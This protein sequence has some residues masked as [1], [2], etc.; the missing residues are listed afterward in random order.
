[1]DISSIIITLLILLFSVVLHELSHG[2]A[3]D[4]LGD[5]T[6]RHAGRL[7]LNPLPHLDPIGSI[8]LPLFLFM[9]NSPVIF[10]AAKPVPVNFANLRDPKRDMALVSLAG[11][12][13]N[14]ILAFAFALPI[15][16][17]MISEG[18]PGFSILLQAVLMNLVLGIFNL[19]PIPP[20]DGSKILASIV[21]DEMMYKILSLERYGFLLIILFLYTG[22][23][24]AVLVPILNALSRVFLGFGIV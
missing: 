21:S 19:I 20:L 4:K 9:V 23:I 5:N 3:A 24:N 14:F 16:L 18:M 1:M 6:A 8:L 12:A 13:T 10:G 22:L 2:V 7:T 11:P 15:R 17:G